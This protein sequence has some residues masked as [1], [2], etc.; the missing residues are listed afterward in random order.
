MA[1]TSSMLPDV[2]LFKYGTDSFSQYGWL[3]M[4]CITALFGLTAGLCAIL[5]D[6]YRTGRVSVILASQ[7]LKG[8]TK[9]GNSKF[10]KIPSHL[11]VLAYSK[12]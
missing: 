11:N 12:K 9:K 10:P 3:I 4:V 5:L 1:L 7:N 6:R 2:S 8:M